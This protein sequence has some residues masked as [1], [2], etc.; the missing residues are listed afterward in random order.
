MINKYV[1]LRTFP[2]QQ[3]IYRGR[4]M[5]QVLSEASNRR[6]GKSGMRSYSGKKVQ[7]VETSTNQTKP[8]GWFGG[9]SCT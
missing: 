5:L 2:C 4:S 3:T 6:L 1:E 7:I 8:L 9:A